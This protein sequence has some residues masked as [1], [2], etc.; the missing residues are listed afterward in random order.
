MV[1]RRGSTW[2]FSPERGG[3]SCS[4][5]STGSGAPNFDQGGR[6]THSV[7]TLLLIY[8]FRKSAKI[9]A[10][11]GTNRS[12]SSSRVPSSFQVWALDKILDLTK[13]NSKASRYCYTEAKCVKNPTHFAL[14]WS[15]LQKRANQKPHIKGAEAR[16]AA[17][18]CAGRCGHPL[19]I[20]TQADLS[21]AF[22][23]F[24]KCS[25]H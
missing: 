19:H 15:I 1:P 12:S 22:S 24:L 25:S 5:F 17:R 11:W 3:G 2:P 20:P 18:K 16:R 21:K 13:E 4:S 8:V 14:V 10:F 9:G 6:R 7:S 23:L